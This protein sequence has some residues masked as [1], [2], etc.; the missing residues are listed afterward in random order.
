MASSK[1]HPCFSLVKS[2]TMSEKRYFK[3]W[4]SKHIIGS[5]N[6]YIELFDALDDQETEDDQALKTVLEDKDV[7]SDFL[8]A[9]KNYLYHLVLK[10][11]NSFHSSKSVNLEVKELLI[12]IEI[13]FDRALYD[14]C[15]KL[16]KRAK[17]LAESVENY[18][19]LV[20]AL[21]WERKCLGYS[22]GIK[23]AYRSNHSIN[24]Y[25]K[26]AINQK[27]FTDLFYKTAVIRQKYNKARKE[28]VLENLK[29]V[30]THPLMQDEKNAL[31]FTSKIK[32]H[33]VYAQYYFVKSEHKKELEHTLA[34]IE[35]IESS[36]LY[37]KENPLEYITLYS[38]LL[39]LR[40]STDRKAFIDDLRILRA[41][42]ESVK[43]SKQKIVDRVFIYSYMSELAMYIECKE[44]EE[45]YALIQKLQKQLEEIQTPVEKGYYLTF[46][47]MFGYL[48]FTVG[49]YN[50]ALKFFNKV[51]NDFREEQ[52]PDLYNQSKILCMLLHFELKNYDLLSYLYNSAI[53]YYRKRGKLYDTEN[54]VLGFFKKVERTPQEKQ[55][56]NILKELVNSLN[57]LKVNEFE[58]N[59]LNLFD[60]AL[61]AEAHLEGKLM[62]KFDSR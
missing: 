22:Q 28:E 39:A 4:S 7:N 3:I 40:R 10:S 16:I 61:W 32:Y 33:Q 1:H 29:K 37:K 48:S 6:K 41:F 42:P 17:F 15:L 25:L 45:G 24:K 11:L 8:S 23:E 54:S 62:S 18:Q 30:V 19:L 44:F 5:Q 51:L 20:D 55:I 13:L 50:K 38:R 57:K 2:L 26:F 49:E 56:K 36:E 14:Q 21:T 35:L 43:L 27:L 9:D 46:Y 58:R 47:Y 59:A 31:T 60:Y 53:H 12:S 34:L 52:R